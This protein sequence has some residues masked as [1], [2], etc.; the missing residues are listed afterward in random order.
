MLAALRNT[1]VPVADTRYG[2]S[3]RVTPR[4]NVQAALESMA[5]NVA[6]DLDGD[7]DVDKEDANI[8][9]A[10]QKEENRP[11]KTGQSDEGCPSFR[12]QTHC[13]PEQRLSHYY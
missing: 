12:A 1:G 6:W 13:L 3:G 11:T 7:C 2:G 10:R 4:I 8:L 5:C 9:K